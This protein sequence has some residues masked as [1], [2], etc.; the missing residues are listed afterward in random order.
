MNTKNSTISGK[1]QPVGP[2]FTNGWL[3]SLDGR[4]G[5]AREL[6]RWFEAI[7]GDLSGYATLS[8][9]D[10]VYASGRYCVVSTAWSWTRKS[11]AYLNMLLWDW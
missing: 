2:Q 11:S 7:A 6:R 4:L 8:Y 10:V 5:I 9:A 1:S 3:D